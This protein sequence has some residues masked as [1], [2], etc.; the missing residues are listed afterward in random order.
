[1]PAF[2]ADDFL[3][4][5][6]AAERGAGAIILSKSTSRLVGPSG[7]V[8]VPVELGRMKVGIHLVCARSALA[9][10]RVRAVAEALSA[11]LAPSA[12]VPRASSEGPPI[13]GGSGRGG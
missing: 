3:V 10:P 2:A 11:E 7:L 13:R 5:L 9:V 4:Q 1:M 6:H 12:R 8:E